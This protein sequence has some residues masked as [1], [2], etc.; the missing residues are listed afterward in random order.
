MLRGVRATRDVA[1]PRE[2]GRPG[3][4]G[5]QERGREGG[6]VPSKKASMVILPAVPPS[7]CS[8]GDCIS[9]LMMRNPVPSSTA[10][11]AS[12]GSVSVSWAWSTTISRAGLSSADFVG[13][14]L[15]TRLADP[16]PS[17]SAMSAC[18]RSSDAVGRLSKSFAMHIS[19]KFFTATF[20]I[21]SSA[22]G[23]LPDETFLKICPAFLHSLKG[24]SL[25]VI[26]R[27]TIPKA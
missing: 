19:M 21:R 16:V 12:G 1:T 20:S 24:Y 3:G 23:G 4:G 17:R 14:S 11:A 25:V 9:A 6:S 10:A 8:S 13:S 7:V 15:S 22:F 2:V 18:A 5:A 26:S 27:I